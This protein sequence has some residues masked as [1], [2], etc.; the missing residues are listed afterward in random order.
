MRKEK[1]LIAL[2]RDLVG[3]LAD[4]ADRNPEFSSRVEQLLETIPDHGTK[5]PRGAGQ[6]H[7]GP[8]PDVHA[9]WSARGDTEFRIWLREQ[10]IPTIRALIRLQDLDPTR[11]TARWKDPEKLAGFVADSLRARMSRG[12]AFIGN[13]SGRGSE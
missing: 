9:E 12:S 5:K 7:V 1:A 4:E 11:R 10:P 2:L 8:L 3:V 6:R 13:T